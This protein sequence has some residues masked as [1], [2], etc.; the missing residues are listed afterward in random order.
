MKTVELKIALLVVGLLASCATSQKPAHGV[1]N[2]AQVKP[3]IWRG[4]Q[5]TAEGWQY[6]KSLGVHTSIKLNP[7]SEASDDL[8]ASNGFTVVYLPITLAQQTIGKPNSN[9]LYAA[10]SAMTNGTFVHCLRGQDRAGLAVG[11]YRVR[12]DHWTKDAAYQEMA[13]H[14][15]HP[16]LR[17]LYW[18][19]E[20]DVP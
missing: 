9:N 15:F 1:P 14:G 4:G 10:V 16:L 7:V 19:W 3:G 5:P 20:E 18:S 13:D 17:G 8:A 2:L 11:A 6:L 12:V